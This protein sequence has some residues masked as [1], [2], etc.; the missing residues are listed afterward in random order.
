MEQTRVLVTGGLGHKGSQLV[1]ELVEKGYEVFIIDNLTTGDKKNLNSK[2]YFIKG[3]VKDVNL[4]RCFMRNVKVVFHL[5]HNKLEDNM[6][7]N[8]TIL[9]LAIESNIPKLVYSIPS[10]TKVS[11]SSVSGKAFENYLEFYNNNKV[12]KIYVTKLKD[13]KNNKEFAKIIE[14]I[15]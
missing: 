10:S 14:W 6:V 2:A 8:L 7:E 9:N 5:A 4:V 3:D 12:I 13:A 15:K 11:I 1:N